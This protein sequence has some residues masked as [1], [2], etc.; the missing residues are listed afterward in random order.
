MRQFL[1]LVFVFLLL[2]AC[3]HT[4]P[5]QK[6][7]LSHAD[8]IISVH[9]DSALHLLKKVGN[10]HHLASSDRALYALLM[11]QALDKCD[12][13]V[14][15]DTLIKIATDY[16]GNNDP[17]RAGYAWFYRARCEKNQGNSQG[18]A[19]AL[20]KAQEY[21]TQS[22]NYKLL[23]FVYSDKAKMYQQQNQLDSMLSCS[24]QAI[25]MFLLIKDYR[26]LG[27][28][29]LYTGQYYSFLNQEDNALSYYLSA[30]DI[31]VKIKDTLLVT[32]CQRNIS[33]IYYKKKDYTAA[34]YYSFESM[35]TH[36]SYDYSKCI[37]LGLIYSQLG[38]MDSAK[39]YLQKFKHPH[40]MIL[41]YYRLWKDIYKKEGQ[42]DNALAFADK[43]LL[44]Q[45]SLYQSSLR[46][47]FA[48]LEKKYNYQRIS[49]ENQALII[50][51][52]HK[53]VIILILLF[54]LS[55]GAALWV[56][57][58][59]RHHKK[60]LDQQKLLTRQEQEL[61]QQAKAREVLLQKQ[62]EIQHNA[63]NSLNI[64]KMLLA[65]LVANEDKEKEKSNR[66][67]SSIQRNYRNTIVKEIVNNVNLLYDNMSKRLADA[68]PNL[69][70][71][72]ILMCCLLLAGLD[73]V[74]IYIILNLQPKSYNVK[75]THIRTKLQ[76]QH[77]TN[78]V[79]F[80]AQF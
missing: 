36:D 48:G 70:E 14:T 38:K 64:L 16:F 12:S 44:T 43:M 74:T 73:N 3:H 27:I 33:F 1:F 41:T 7:L 2:T 10:F 51:N 67:L 4:T 25:H 59:K 54:V 58:R 61:K 29:L 77:E 30:L 55:L 6:A 62:I 26:N 49:T 42:L 75:R 56:V 40:E 45:D 60:L 20:L 19:D 46:E 39:F 78:L 24:T 50:N 21:A 9:P 8:S 31:A 80:L 22:K 76:L 13:I 52:Q 5:E 79:D 18:Q 35:K 68:F 57:L 11:T 47:S 65:E 72:D 23:G 37:N 63:L 53:Y 69:L 71:N 28:G 34:R 66:F 32:S 15:S 17:V